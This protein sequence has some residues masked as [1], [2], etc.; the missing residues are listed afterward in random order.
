MLLKHME[1][2]PRPETQQIRGKTA[3]DRV[4]EPL[5][6]PFLMVLTPF[7]YLANARHNLP[8]AVTV[9]ERV[10]LGVL[11]NFHSGTLNPHFFMYPSIY[12]YVTYFLTRPFAFSD[13]LFTG[14]LLNLSF[15]GLTAYFAYLCCRDDFRS[16]S[17]GLLSAG[18]IILS[19][20]MI[21]SGSYLCTDVMLA[22]ATMASLWLVNRYFRLPSSKNWFVAM[23]AIGM[24]VACK[25]T[26]FLLFLVYALIEVV[27]R[28]SDRGDASINAP[29][30]SRIPRVPLSCTVCLIGVAVLGL[31]L[32]FPTAHALH[33]G[34]ALQTDTEQHLWST[35]SEKPKT[36]SDYLKI[37]HHLRSLLLIIGGG[38]AAFGLLILK[39]RFAYR[40]ISFKRLYLGFGIVLLISI[41][42]TPYS[43]ITPVKFSYDMRQLALGNVFYRA[44]HAQWGNYVTWLIEGESG[45]LVCLG[46]MG[47]ILAAFQER[48]RYLTSLI[49][50]VVFMF[51]LGASHRGY[52]HYL[53][54]LLPVW[55]VF[56]A[57]LI[58]QTWGLATSRHLRYG[59]LLASAL[60]IIVAVQLSVRLREKHALQQ[61]TDEFWRSYTLAAGRAPGKLYFAAYAPSVELALKG[62]QV[63]QV[64]WA[65][66][67]AHP[68][69]GRLAC[70]DL[71]I[72]D[73]RGARRNGFTVKDDP[74]VRDLLYDPEAYGQEVIEKAG[75]P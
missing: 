75:C 51:T 11:K 42:C 62:Y 33:L 48:S 5:L 7:L 45:V 14:R 8:V 53:T 32:F 2:E 44:D 43:L 52:P 27:T 68:I 19:P 12:Y 21:D 58:V 1:V 67:N 65:S 22:A 55:Y 39:S 57:N 35:F 15:V 17:S 16:R 9:D 70:G 63:Q 74:S 69:G 50:S 46:L 36:P 29:D 54:P 59:R 49:F 41:L 64:G 13:I 56:A 47:V 37:F 61:T 31:G 25:Y 73:L 60:I 72:V 24:A 38:I 4:F 18:F 26:A 30:K 28:F 10:G 6:L 40:L 66:L 20:T 3:M 71:V 34:I 23:V